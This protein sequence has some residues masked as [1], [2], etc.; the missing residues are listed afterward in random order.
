MSRKIALF[1]LFAGPSMVLFILFIIIPFVFGIYL[2]MTNWDGFSTA[3]EFVGFRNYVSIFG[4]KEFWSSIWLTIK[5]VTAC[6][7]FVNG[8]AFLLAYLLSSG[9]KGENFLRAGFF[10][11]NLIGGIVLGFIWQFIF[12]RVLTML[13]I[14]PDQSFL[15]DPIKAF[16]AMVIVETWRSSGYM[17]LIYIAGFVGVS[18]DY[19]EAARIDGANSRQ[20]LWRIRLPLMMQSFTIC[21]FLTLSSAMKVYDMNLSLTDGGPYGATRMAAMTIFDKAF[22]YHDYGMGQSEAVVFF[23]IMLV[24]AIVQLNVTRKREVNA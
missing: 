18:R 6:V 14:F 24:I 4:E 11:P 8:I 13:P 17:L 3:K 15:S 16:W 2:T 9:I 23:L 21:L 20:I 12:N 22:T 10:T 5:Y 7:I 1:L 19:I